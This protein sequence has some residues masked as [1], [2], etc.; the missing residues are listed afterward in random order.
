MATMRK[1]L[2]GMD[3]LAQIKAAGTA[4]GDKGV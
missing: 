4:P 2:V 3:R 1:A